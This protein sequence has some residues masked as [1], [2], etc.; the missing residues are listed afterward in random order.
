MTTTAIPPYLQSALDLA[1]RLDAYFPDGDP[2]AIARVR[3]RIRDLV[4]LV[5]NRDGQ[6]Q[7]LQAGK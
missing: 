5:A 4:D 2:E 7:K 1:N 3:K 6:I